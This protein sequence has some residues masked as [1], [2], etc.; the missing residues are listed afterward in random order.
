MWPRC[1]CQDVGVLDA[2]AEAARIAA[3]VDGKNDT[4]VTV[5]ADVYK[6]RQFRRAVSAL[7]RSKYH[8]S[9]GTNYQAQ[10]DGSARVGVS[11]A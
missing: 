8:L 5:R 10:A 7:L 3:Q 11:Q 1:V 4:T 6:N 2:S 9:V